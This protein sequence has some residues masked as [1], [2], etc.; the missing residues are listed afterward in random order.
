MKNIN[1]PHSGRISNHGKGAGPVTSRDVE[2]RAIEIARIEGHHTVLEED[3]QRAVEELRGLDLGPAGGDQV[4]TMDSI[5]RDPSDP[6]ANRGSQTPN[7]E[8]SDEQKMPEMLVAEGVEEA[9]HEL[10]LEARRR[11]KES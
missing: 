3:R 11:Q 2:D 7:F 6:P 9:D 8:G 10:M 5:S 1:P 4:E